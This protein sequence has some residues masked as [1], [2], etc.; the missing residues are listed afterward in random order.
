MHARVSY[1]DAEQDKVDDVLGQVE[2][3]IVPSMKDQDGFKGFTVLVERSSGRLMAISFWDSEDAMK[4]SEEWADQSRGEAAET[5]GSP[6]PRVERY[7]VAIDV[8][9]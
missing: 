7:E 3:D 2:S 4:A 1:L 6:E 8:M 5:A 9:E